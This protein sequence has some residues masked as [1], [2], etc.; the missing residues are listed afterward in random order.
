MGL[1]GGNLKE[2]Q[3]RYLLKKEEIID[4]SA[5]INPLG[6]PKSVGKII[7]SYLDDI[8]RYPDPDCRDLKK[9]LAGCLNISADNLLIGNGSMDL[10]FSLAFALKPK[11][12]LIPIPAFSEYERAVHLAG[13]RCLF[14]KTHEKNDFAVNVTEIVKR[15][16]SVD[17][18]FI[19]NPN[20]PT[21]F[22]WDKEAMRFLAGKCEKNGVFLVIDEAF[23]DFVEEK[24]ASS[25]A[26]AR[27]YR[28]HVLVLRSL[29]KF[30]ALAGLRIGYLAG[31]KKLLNR[32]SS[33]QPPWSVNVLA[34]MTACEIIRDSVFIKKSRDYVLKESSFLF[35]ELQK[36]EFLKPYPVSANFIFCRLEDKKINARRLCDYCGGKGILIRDCSNFRGLDG[37]FVRI[38][39]R[40]REENV[41]LLSCLEGIF[42]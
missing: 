17:L 29:T 4:F 39:V 5:N 37:R 3:E 15:L 38:A 27:P 33:Y 42:K 9:A 11:R 6:F 8:A 40:R 36:L 23:M 30:F 2:A 10:I 19:C 18:L 22:L 13:G 20:N 21:G 7:S 1:H 34:Q 32:I 35:K 16:D 41:L 25:M 24:N 14:V 31:N 12:A 28:K 26:A